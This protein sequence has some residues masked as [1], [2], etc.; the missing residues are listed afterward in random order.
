M[1]VLLDACIPERLR[2][3]LPGHEV[4]TVRYAGLDGLTDKDLLDATEG[5]FDVLVTCDQGIPW[6]QNLRGRS[7]G[8]ALLKA[9]SNRLADLLPLV[10]ELLARLHEISPGRVL[11]VPS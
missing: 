3:A 1:R 10:P 5:S 11:E 9:P 4:Q 8:L 6:Q 2:L 7:V